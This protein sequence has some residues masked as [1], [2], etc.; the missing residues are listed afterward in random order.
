MVYSIN[1]QRNNEYHNY[2]F[3]RSKWLREHNRYWYAENNAW[4]Q[5][6]RIY[7]IFVGIFIVDFLRWM[8]FRAFVCDYF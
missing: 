1:L 5:D 4:R 3:V 6:E 2:I 7:I 8:I